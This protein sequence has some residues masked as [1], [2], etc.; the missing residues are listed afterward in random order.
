M[1][2]LLF[3]SR[4]AAAAAARFSSFFG[5]IAWIDCEGRRGPDGWLKAFT[6]TRKGLGEFVAKDLADGSQWLD[7]GNRKNAVF[8]PESAET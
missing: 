7:S 4:N 3:Q 5:K 1:K 6:M 2:E 8:C